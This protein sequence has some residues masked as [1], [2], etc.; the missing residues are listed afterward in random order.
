MHILVNH[1]PSRLEGNRSTRQK[2]REAARELK[3]VVDSICQTDPA[4]KIVVT[5]DFNDGPEAHSLRK[6]FD[7]RFINPLSVALKR[8]GTAQY[9]KKWVLFDQIL[10]N[11][12]LLH[13]KT[14]TLREA[15]VFNPPFLV[16]PHGRFRG[17]PK[18]TFAGR[19]YQGG[20][21]DHFPV[22][23]LFDVHGSMLPSISTLSRS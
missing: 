2:R 17:A 4:A 15:L 1:W 19:H 7:P 13:S 3:K 22:Y 12:N 14:L 16:Q 5:G 20:F 10:L 6:D 23:A 8:T 18:R 21:S 11:E 9:R